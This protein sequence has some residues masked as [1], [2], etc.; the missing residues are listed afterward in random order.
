MKSRGGVVNVSNRRDPNGANQVR[1]RL[2]R[3]HK[4]MKH[5]QGSKPHNHRRNE[6]KLHREVSHHEA[7][8]HLVHRVPITTNHLNV[9]RVRSHRV[10]SLVVLSP[11]VPNRLGLNLLDR[12]RR[13]RSHHGLSRRAMN[14]E[15]SRHR[16]RR[17]LITTNHLNVRPVRSRSGLSLVVLNP[18]VRRR[19][20]LNLLVRRRQ[21][22][23]PHVPNRLA[24]SRHVHLIQIRRDRASQINHAGK[25]KS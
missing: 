10:L 16:V 4:E 1:Q 8:R 5:L 18:H 23:N 9:R 22:L 13:V 11:H 21:D 19:Q 2:K 6:V 15:A 12:S 7:S 25:W 17:V 14:K 3:G 20:D 24:Q